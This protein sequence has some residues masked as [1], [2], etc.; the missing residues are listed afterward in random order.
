MKAAALR[1][2]SVKF[3]GFSLLGVPDQFS[4]DCLEKVQDFLALHRLFPLD[5]AVKDRR[6]AIWAFFSFLTVF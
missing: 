5:C 2:D 6:I 1:P 3:E 4:I